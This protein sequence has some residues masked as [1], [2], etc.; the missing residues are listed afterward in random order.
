VADVSRRLRSFIFVATTAGLASTVSLI[1]GIGLEH[2]AK[3]LLPLVPL[4]VAMPALSDMVGDYSSIIAAHTGDPKQRARSRSQL[5]QSILRVVG[6]NIAGIVILSL[7]IAGLRGYI[8]DGYFVIRFA[9]FVAAAILTIIGA[10]LWLNRVLDRVL[11][12]HKYNPDDLLIPIST[13]LADIMMI[14]LVT[15]AVLT[16]FR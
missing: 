9:V 4:L 11:I 13:S 15:L 16:I 6:I 1:G 12:A 7:T 14:G 10:M 5:A 8:A 2:I 3:R